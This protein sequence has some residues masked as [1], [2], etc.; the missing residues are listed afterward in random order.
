MRLRVGLRKSFA[1]DLV[2]KEAGFEVGA[3]GRVLDGADAIAQIEFLCAL[4]DRTQQALQAAAKIRSLADV[5]LGLGVF[6]AQ[7]EH[8]RRGGDGGEDFRVAFGGELQALGQHEIIVSRVF[9]ADL[10]QKESQ[11]PVQ[12]SEIMGKI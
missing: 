8:S 11:P 7:Q 12:P 10:I 2:E 9:T 1:Q 3:G 4:F 6:A 5:R